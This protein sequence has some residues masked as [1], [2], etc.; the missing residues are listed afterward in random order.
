M[1]YY[2]ENMSYDNGQWF[3]NLLIP[4]NVELNDSFEYMSGKQRT[5]CA[6]RNHC[7]YKGSTQ[8]F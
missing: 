7:F 6:K 5:A 1:A 8:D 3:A 2:Y 4:S